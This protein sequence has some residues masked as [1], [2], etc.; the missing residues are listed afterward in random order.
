MR[1]GNIKP[2]KRRRECANSVRRLE[3]EPK[4][5]SVCLAWGDCCGDVLPLCVTEGGNWLLSLSR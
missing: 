5:P 3:A 2:K 1:D 4:V